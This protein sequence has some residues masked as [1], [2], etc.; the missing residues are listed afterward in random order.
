MESYYPILLMIILGIITATAFTLMAALLGPKKNS[1][2]KELPFESGMLP[3]VN[4]NKKISVKFYLVAMSFLIFD[5][6]A[7]FFYPWATIFN[8]NRLYALLAILPFVT[9][10]LIGL[11]YDWKKGALEWE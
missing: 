11:A 10:L 8:D 4:K 7:M 9:L 3:A 5:V 2:E 1:P 6:E